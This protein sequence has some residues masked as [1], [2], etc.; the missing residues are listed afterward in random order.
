VDVGEN[1]LQDL[2][3]CSAFG[4]ITQD[5]EPIPTSLVGFGEWLQHRMPVSARQ[6][7]VTAHERAQMLLVAV[8]FR[9]H[10]VPFISWFGC[11]LPSVGSHHDLRVQSPASYCWTTRQMVRSGFG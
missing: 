9:P 6:F 8:F 10:T 5:I 3:V 1:C 2:S 7:L 4:T 11:W